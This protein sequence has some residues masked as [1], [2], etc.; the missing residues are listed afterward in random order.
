MYV[1]ILKTIGFLAMLPFAFAFAII[2]IWFLESVIEKIQK[3]I[4]VG[5][6][7]WT[8]KDIR[9]KAWQTWVDGDKE[10]CILGVDSHGSVNVL[11][12]HDVFWITKEQWQDKID[13]TNIYLK[14]K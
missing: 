5:A 11:V 3:T 4:F 10:L 7:H 12:N 9:P 13:N 14:S 1:T 2:V 6:R 8:T